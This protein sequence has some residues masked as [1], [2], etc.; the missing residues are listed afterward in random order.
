MAFLWW[1]FVVPSF[2][3]TASI[4]LEISFTQ[5]F[6]TFQLQTV[7]LH[8]WSNLHNRKTSISQKRKKIFQKEKCHSSI[9]WK[10]FQISRNYF[11]RHIHLNSDPTFCM[12][13]NHY[14]STFIHCTNA[15]FL[16]GWFVPRDTGL[17]QNKLIEVIIVV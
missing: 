8:H 5:Y 10:A 12:N 17:W 11:T 16:I 4:F 15:D 7:W 13:V 9:L 3:N 14:H 2:K 1:T 6:T